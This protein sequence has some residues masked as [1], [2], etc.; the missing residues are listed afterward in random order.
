MVFLLRKCL[1]YSRQ[2]PL[3]SLLPLIPIGGEPAAQ[4]QQFVERTG[5]HDTAILQENDVISIGDGVEPM[6]HQV[7]EDALVLVL[8]DT[9]FP[10]LT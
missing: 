7:S 1:C 10:A 4:R 9:H 8:G 2:F 5:L 3:G 6:G